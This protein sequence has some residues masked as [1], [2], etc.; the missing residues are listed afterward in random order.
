MAYTFFQRDR[1]AAACTHVD[2]AEAEAEAVLFSDSL[3]NAI[4]Q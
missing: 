3:E 4:H 2:A 1:L